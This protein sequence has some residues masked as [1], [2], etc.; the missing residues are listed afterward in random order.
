MNTPRRPLPSPTV[1]G[2]S[3]GSGIAARAIALRETQREQQGISHPAIEPVAPAP[4]QQLPVTSFANLTGAIAEVMANVGTIEKGGVNKHFG[5]KYARMEDLLHAL[6]PLMGKNG[7]AV[8]QS[9]VEIKM[10]ETRVAVTYEFIVTHKSGERMPAQRFTGMALARDG[11]GNFDDKC[12]NKA[13]TNARKYF[14]LSLFQVP[15][16]DF[17]DTDAGDD[18]R[19]EQSRTVPGPGAAPKQEPT[20][21][22]PAQEGWRV[23]QRIGLGQGAGADQWVRRFI[24]CISYCKTADEVRSWDALNDQALQNLS[25][26]YP[27]MYDQISAAMEQKLEGFGAVDTKAE[28]REQ[29]DEMPLD[30]Q[31]A[32]NWIAT[33]L[34]GF[35]DYQAGEDFWNQ[36]VA[37]KETAF[38]APD[39]EMLEQ[40]WQRFE[41][42][43][44]QS[45][46]GQE[47]S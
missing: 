6:T 39:W 36:Q 25:D 35:K 15:A 24:N 9:E 40:E 17:E 32:M 30:T 4:H 11:K 23:P 3:S 38:D 22:E 42:K 45:V 13:H 10:V 14:L 12:L 43:F 34:Q 18:T 33:K 16:G 8:W 44:P 46:E 31:E 26:K 7:I 1:P 5:Y 27:K 29:D 20:K 2:P 28:M 21:E 41:T 37:P 47:A 19:P